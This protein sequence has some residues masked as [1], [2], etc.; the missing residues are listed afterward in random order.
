MKCMEKMNSRQREERDENKHIY[1]SNEKKVQ[2]LLKLRF[3]LRYIDSEFAYRISD[4]KLIRFDLVELRGKELVFI[5]L[6]LITDVRLSRKEK[7]A[8]SVSQEEGKLEIVNQMEKYTK[9]IQEHE[10]DFKM[11]YTKVL[12][13][14]KR[15]GLWKGE[16]DVESVSLKPELWIV[17]TY[18]KDNMSKGRK[19]RIAN[20][21][22]LKECT[23]F[24]TF[25]VD[26]QKLCK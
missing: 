22:K 18:D 15:L 2:G 1:T 14:K 19:D 24:E 21:E 12:Q 20:L 26:Y 9:F 3:P 10:E 25:I 8:H 16:T 11:Y 7:N 23:D 13:I 5:E 4:K 17:N 6:K